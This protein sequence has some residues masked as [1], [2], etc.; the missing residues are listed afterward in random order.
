MKE[1]TLEVLA[2][3]L[4][5]AGEVGL[6]G[7]EAAEFCARRCGRALDDLLLFEADMGDQGFLDMVLR[8]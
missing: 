4:N 2:K 7:C 1:H 8:K 6:E 3:E 5:G